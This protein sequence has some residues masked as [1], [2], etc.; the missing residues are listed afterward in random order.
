[1][2]YCCITIDYLSQL[3]RS[4]VREAGAF[5]DELRTIAADCG[6]TVGPRK[7]PVLVAFPSGGMF[8]GKIGRASCRERV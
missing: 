4:G 2:L 5:I 3:E 6:A 1:M 7:S 8:D